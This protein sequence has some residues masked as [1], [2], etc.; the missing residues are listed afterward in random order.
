MNQS[1][2]GC[3]G[4]QANLMRQYN[5]INDILP[6]NYNGSGIAVTWQPEKI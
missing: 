2:P 6:N 1:L 5:D 4:G 3:Y